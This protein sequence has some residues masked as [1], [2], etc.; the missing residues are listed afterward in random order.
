MLRAA[1]AVRSV[2]FLFAG[3]GSERARM[4]LA[5]AEH[6]G[7]ARLLDLA[8]ELAGVDLRRALERGGR[9]LERT[10]VIQPALTAVALVALRALTAAGIR[11]D[12]VAGHSVGEIAAWS[13]AGGPHA[14]EAVPLAA[15]RGRWMAREAALHPGGMLAVVDGPAA[16]RVALVHLAAHNA[17]DE[18]IVSGA[19]DALA[20][21]MAAMP[22]RRLDVVGAWHSPAMA[23]CVAELRNAMR[24]ASRGEERGEARVASPAR[25][26]ANQ[27]CEVAAPDTIPDRL[28]GQ[29]VAPVQWVRTLRTLAEEGLTD[30]VTVGPGKVLRA[31]VRR[32]LGD[33]LRIH[34]T[35][36][37]ADLARTLAALGAR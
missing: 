35:E 36:D 7:D 32:N 4:G 15:A 13:A 33:A 19:E 9:A 31:L 18:W 16:C 8:G 29:L 5:L 37:P 3:Q 28:A 20:A 25:F 21:V 17:H 24:L 14:E 27:T 12:L 23:G 22:A 34:G 1:R 6:V 26:V 2:G 30:V 10:E 11:P